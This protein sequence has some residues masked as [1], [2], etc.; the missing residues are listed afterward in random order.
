[1]RR[2]GPAE[3]EPEMTAGQLRTVVEGIIAAGHWK[4]GD[5]KILALFDAGYNVAR[6]SWL[7]ADLPLEVI[8]HLRSDRVLRTDP[9]PASS[10]AGR[11]ARHGDEFKLQDPDA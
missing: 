10:G 5:Q 11:P 2:L 7:L 4:A 6:I 8:G 3:Q 9:L 1:M